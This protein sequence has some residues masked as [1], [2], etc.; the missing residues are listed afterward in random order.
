MK[1]ES[2]NRNNIKTI[3][4]LWITAKKKHCIR[5]VSDRKT[6]ERLPNIQTMS[7]EQRNEACHFLAT[8]NSVM[9]I[10]DS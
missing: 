4:I 5:L 3:I 9:P 2:I 8:I 6:P 1:E 10:S 7:I